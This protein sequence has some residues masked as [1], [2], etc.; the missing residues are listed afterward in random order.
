M[1][2]VTQHHKEQ[3]EKADG[4]LKVH[5]ILSI[6]FGGLG[7]LFGLLFMIMMGLGSVASMDLEDTISAFAIGIFAF[8]LF[9][10]PH[11]YLI[12]AGSYLLKTPPVRTARVLVII[13]IVIGALWNL[14]L[15]VFAI[16]NLTQIDEYERGYPHNKK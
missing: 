6:I 3:F 5:G 9:V 4:L 2:E 7:V 1:A 16:I 15:L 10:L 8:V 14:V 13:N 12:I 11:I